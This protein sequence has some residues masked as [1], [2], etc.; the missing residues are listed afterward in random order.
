MN[1]VFSLCL[2]SC[3]SAVFAAPLK[4]DR[5]FGENMVLPFNK[6]LI[7]SGEGTPGE[8]ITVS[9]GE[10]SVIGKIQSNEKWAVE[11]PPQTPNKVGQTLSVKQKDEVVKLENVLIGTLWLA[12]GQSNMLFKMKESNSGKNDIPMANNVNIR[13]LNCVPQVHTA[14]KAYTQADLD[15]IVPEKFYEGEWRITSPESIPMVSAVAYYFAVT[16]QEQLDM[17]VGIIHSSLG[18]AGMVSWLPPAFMKKNGAYSTAIG[19]NWLKSPL[20]SSFIRERATQNL[21]ALINK[22]EPQHPYKPGFL[23]EAGIE[24]IKPLAL[25]GVI[26]YQGET[27]AENNDS[28]QNIMLLRDLIGT[29]RA[30]FNE[31]RLPFIMV[32]LPRINDPRPTRAFWA[33]FRAVQEL[34]A[35]NIP[36]VYLTNTIDLGATNSE[37]HPADKVSVGKRLAY[38]ALGHLYKKDVPFQDPQFKSMKIVGDKVLVKFD[39]A[40]GICTSDGQ[41]P[42]QFEIADSSGHFVPAQ[43]KIEPQGHLTLTA[44]G[45]KNPKKVRYCW[46]TSVN[47]NLINKDKLPARPFIEPK[48]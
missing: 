5:V 8:S 37:V 48:Q 21:S 44:E 16:L 45:V 20:C 9:L 47:P 14:G 25:N 46:A 22:G 34:A 43:A 29:W 11:F 10:Q 3:S 35:Q 23:F 7:I 4:F 13:I 1:W 17:P 39:H 2:L 42:T 41:A 28:K 27:D 36:D 38:T 19:N 30:Y 18:G 32:Q 31:P 12:S 26:W 24:W 40:E 6:K 15:R 33:E